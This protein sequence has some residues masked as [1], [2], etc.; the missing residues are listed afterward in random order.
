MGRIVAVTGTGTGVGKTVL[1]AALCAGLRRRGMDCRAVKM[2]ATGVP[3]G[4]DAEDAVLLGAAM[5]AAASEA[6]LA[7][8]SLPRSPLAAAAA[9][10]RE[11]DVEAL[12][13][14]IEAAATGCELL[15]VEGVGGL[16]VPLS[17]RRTVR[18]LLRR[19]DAGVVV[20]ALM[21]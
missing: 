15:L 13:R 4:T 6:V 18:D 3:P 17:P 11:L 9:E 12:A 16:L 21:R 8:F 5:G 2:V 1:T 14:S 10:G 20:A 19:L 7:T